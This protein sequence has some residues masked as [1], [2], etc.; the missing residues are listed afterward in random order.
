MPGEMRFRL[1]MGDAFSGA[2]VPI[3]PLSAEATTVSRPFADYARNMETASPGT[4]ITIPET[5]E[6]WNVNL[7]KH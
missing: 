7:I 4:R 1:A 2:S 6:G 5:P 3:A